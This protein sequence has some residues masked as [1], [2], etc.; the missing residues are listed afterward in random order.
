MNPKPVSSG[1]PACICVCK[2]P[3]PRLLLLPQTRQ[4]STCARSQDPTRPSP[5]RTSSAQRAPPSPP[6]STHPPVPV[7]QIPRLV[8]LVVLLPPPPRGQQS[9]TNEAYYRS[10]KRATSHSTACA[11]SIPKRPRPSRHPTAANSPGSSSALRLIPSPSF[12][13]SHSFPLPPLCG[14]SAHSPF[15]FCLG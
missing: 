13:P 9:A 1:K 2:N 14:A 11:C 6:P 15:P 7:P 12:L 3:F 8:G 10:C 4:H 5:L